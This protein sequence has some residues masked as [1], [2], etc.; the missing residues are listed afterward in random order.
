MAKS[1][2][3]KTEVPGKSQISNPKSQ[4]NSKFQS[5]NLKAEELERAVEVAGSEDAMKPVTGEGGS[6]LLWAQAGGGERV[7]PPWPALNAAGSDLVRAPPTT[8]G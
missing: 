2:F 5:S 8:L 1:A 7:E 6:G 3:G 4:G